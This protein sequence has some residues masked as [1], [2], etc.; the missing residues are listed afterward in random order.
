MALNNFIATVWAAAILRALKKSHVFA[1]DK[2]INRDYEGEIKDKGDSVKIL[3]VGDIT[4]KSYTKNQKL[5]DPEILKDAEQMI[6]ITEGDYFRFLVDDADKVQGNPKVMG[7]AMDRAGYQLRDKS[8]RFLAGKYTEISL[9]NFIG[10]DGAPIV[11][12]ASN[13]Y[14]YLVDLGVVLSE[15]DTPEEDRWC[16]VP[17]W[18]YGLLQKDPRFVGYGTPGNKETLANGVVG[19]AAG[20]EIMKSNNVS[21]INGTKYKIMAG[22]KSAWSYAE[23]I[24]EMDM[25]KHPDY[26]GEQG[27]GRHLYGAKVVRASNL[28]CLVASKS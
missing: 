1:S 7:E 10:S 3:S 8:D 24:D 11:P 27:R 17:A 9:T 25:M 14:D 16:V 19:E 15:S 2:V 13:A 4:V 18:F 20:F 5:D 22:H 26:F 23:Q 12:T 6:S 21:N 28:A